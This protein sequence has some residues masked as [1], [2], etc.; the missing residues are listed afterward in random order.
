MVDRIISTDFLRQCIVALIPLG[1]PISRNA[2]LVSDL[3]RLQNTDRSGGNRAHQAQSKAESS[4]ALVTSIPDTLQSVKDSSLLYQLISRLLLSP[5]QD[6]QLSDSLKK[7]AE[8]AANEQTDIDSIPEVASE[9]QLNSNDG[10]FSLTVEVEIIQIQQ[11]TLTI[12]D[13]FGSIT[14]Q[15]TVV[16]AISIR[17]EV[18]LVQT[19]P[20]K[21]DPLVID[22]DGDGFTTTGIEQGAKFDIN[23]DGVLDQVS[24]TQDDDAFLALDIN[25]NGLIDNG[26]ELFGDQS[27]HVNGF[28]NLAS[29]DENHDGKIDGNDQIF[30]SLLMMRLVDN[31]QFISALSDTDIKSINLDYKN[32]SGSTASGDSVVQISDYQNSKGQKG[33]IADLLLQYKSGISD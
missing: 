19:E 22:V 33:V 20:E 29:Y 14:Q 27:G 23:A 13:D 21:A 10:Q 31:E 7:N 9:I 4:S 32:I 30:N 12:T 8:T 2:T 24:V 3:P 6:Q 11:Q 17:L 26:A 16:E 25:N 18:S 28:A 5:E 1:N 15:S